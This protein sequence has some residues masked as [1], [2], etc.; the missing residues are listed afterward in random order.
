MQVLWLFFCK[1]VKI[2]T[3][4]TSG[5]LVDKDTHNISNMQI[6]VQDISPPQPRKEK[7]EDIQDFIHRFPRPLI[8]QGERKG[9]KK[10]PL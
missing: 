5:P 10:T 1:K 2:N 4:S 6:K 8:S 7:I 3:K 9:K